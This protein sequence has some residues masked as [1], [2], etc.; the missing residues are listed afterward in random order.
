[1][2][3]SE[4]TGS[5]LGLSAFEASQNSTTRWRPGVQISEPMC[6]EH[7]HPNQTERPLPASQNVTGDELAFSR[8]FLTTPEA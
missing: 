3:Q 4:K 5:V 7:S 8:P 1:M 2:K 6:R